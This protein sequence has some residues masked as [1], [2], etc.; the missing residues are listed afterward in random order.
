M[1]QNY[2]K[3]LI[4]SFAVQNEAQDWPFGGGGV[5]VHCIMGWDR[6][7]TFIGLLR[8]S[9]WADGI[10]NPSLSATELIYL[11]IAYDWIS[12]GCVLLLTD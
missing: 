2:I 1:T 4:G 12:F 7:P 8:M 10:V 5:L 3:L 9:L 11:S 6:T